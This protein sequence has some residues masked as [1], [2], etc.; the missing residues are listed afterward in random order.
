[1]DTLANSDLLH[2]AYTRRRE[3]IYGKQADVESERA[4]LLEE[5]IKTARRRERN[6][7]D[8]CA[9][10]A[11]DTYNTLKVEW[12]MAQAR[13]IELERQLA[14]L[15]PP[16]RPAAADYSLSGLSRAFEMVRD[17]A[18]R[19]EQ[20]EI[21]TDVVSRIS[22]ADGSLEIECAV[23]LKRYCLQDVHADNGF[24]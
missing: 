20:R 5:A 13:R 14:A 12:K 11:A 9:D 17:K 22:Y 23:P 19:E 8:M 6:L 7:Q 21:L 3:E 2:A 15:L 24:P 1:M 16:S 18:N 10:A 4:A